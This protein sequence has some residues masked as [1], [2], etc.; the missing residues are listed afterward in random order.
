MGQ[1]E[2][3]IIYSVVIHVDV[4]YKPGEYHVT[5]STPTHG[6]IQMKLRVAATPPRSPW[7]CAHALWIPAGPRST[8]L[9]ENGN[10]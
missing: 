3:P 1:S 9:S 6:W 10:R 4:V 2:I 5:G 7:R 8:G